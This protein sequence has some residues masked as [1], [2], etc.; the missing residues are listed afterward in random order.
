MA[1]WTR[2]SVAKLRVPGSNHTIPWKLAACI[3]EVLMMRV[4]PNWGACYRVYVISAH[5]TSVNNQNMP[6]HHSST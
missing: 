3:M 1:D 6:N 5:K 2:Y 4:F